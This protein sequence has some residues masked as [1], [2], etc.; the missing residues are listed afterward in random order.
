M[1]EEQIAFLYGLPPTLTLEIEG[2]GRVLFCHA[3][4]RERHGRVHRGDAGGAGRAE[5]D[6]V[7]ADLVVVGHTHMQFDREIAG[8]RVV[9]AG[10]VGMAFEDEPGA[11]WT[12]L[13]PT[14][15]HSGRHSPYAPNDWP[16]TK[17]T[18]TR[19]VALF[20]ETLAVGS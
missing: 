6:G 14:V 7:D 17:P 20:T 8:V 1:T 15:E 9:N 13:G 19:A 16:D 10:S 18:P 5:F 12:L 2:L 3:V 11:Y 4:A